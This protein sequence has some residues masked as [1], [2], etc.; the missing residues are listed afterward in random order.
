MGE[1]F[2][3]VEPYRQLR[4]LLSQMRLEGLAVGAGGR[5]RCLLSAY[6][7]LTGRNQPSNAKFIFGPAVWLRNLI[8][9]EPGYGLAY[10][11]WG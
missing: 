5:S 3:I 10:I 8:R 7:S 2:P 11:D 6:R 4:F 9:P 1:R